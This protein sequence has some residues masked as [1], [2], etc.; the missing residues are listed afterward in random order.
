MYT[1]GRGNK[2]TVQAARTEVML[3]RTTKAEKKHAHC[4]SVY[5]AQIYSP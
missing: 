1:T 2:P 5:F 3:I 4:I